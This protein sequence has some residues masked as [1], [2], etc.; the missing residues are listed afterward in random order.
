MQL[1]P[2]THSKGRNTRRFCSTRRTRRSKI[3]MHARIHSI[4][5]CALRGTH[6][7]DDC[8]STQLDWEHRSTNATH[9]HHPPERR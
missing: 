7:L 4:A 5:R 9:A 6:L 3:F 2:R 1:F 8:K